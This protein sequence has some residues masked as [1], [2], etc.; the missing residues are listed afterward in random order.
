MRGKKKEEKK[1]Q[2]T[3]LVSPVIL[4]KVPNKARGEK[5]IVTIEIYLADTPYFSSQER[6]I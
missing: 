5:K 6:G 3:N 2:K 4:K 1:T